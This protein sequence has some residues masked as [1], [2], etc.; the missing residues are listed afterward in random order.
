M[1]RLSYALIGTRNK[2]IANFKFYIV[3]LRE[4]FKTDTAGFQ[5]FFFFLPDSGSFL[6]TLTE[7]QISLASLV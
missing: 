5:S 7:L 1:R 2:E 3:S 4:M 6:R